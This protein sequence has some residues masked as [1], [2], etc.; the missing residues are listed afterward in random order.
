MNSKKSGITI[1]LMS[2]FLSFYLF[3]ISAWSEKLSFFSNIRY[4]TV[5]LICSDRDRDDYYYNGDQYC[6]YSPKLGSTLLLPALFFILGLLLQKEIIDQK[7]VDSFLE[8]L[9]SSNNNQKNE[10]NSKQ[11][12]RGTSYMKSNNDNSYNCPPGTAYS[13]V[14]SPDGEN[15]AIEVAIMKEHRFAFYYW[16]KWAKENGCDKP[17]ALVSIDWHQDLCPP[18]EP[19]QQELSQVNLNSYLEVARYSWEG[20]NPL[21]DGHIL[22]AAYLNLIGN[23][24]VLCKQ[25]IHEPIFTMMDIN[26]KEHKVYCFNDQG[27]LIQALKESEETSIYLDIDLD[28]FTESTDPCGGGEN[29]TVM[30]KQQIE[31][32][33]STDGFFMQWCFKR[34]QGMTIATE[35]EFCGGLKNS[36]NIFNIIDSKLFAVPLFGAKVKWRHLNA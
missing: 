10:D 9:K 8:K 12:N 24:Y 7:T 33:I 5:G 18:C 20:L 17:K 21:N 32:V 25:D 34:M 31:E 1:I 11:E 16:F 14:A 22:A 35:P 3:S 2:L 4:A 15:R 6:K 26:D 27:T 30:S 23:I 36:N 29:L 28:Y 19:E 13:I